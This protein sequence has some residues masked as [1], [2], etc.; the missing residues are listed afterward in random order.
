[1]VWP[2]YTHLIWAEAMRINH[3]SG[4]RLPSDFDISSSYQATIVASTSQLYNLQSRLLDI[5][6]S[7]HHHRCSRATGSA[8]TG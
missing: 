6:Q 5:H 3:H 1:M 8:T 4:E 7:C 2:Q